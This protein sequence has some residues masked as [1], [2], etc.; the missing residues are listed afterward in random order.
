[1]SQRYMKI[2]DAI[3]KYKVYLMQIYL[4]YAE[5]I[6]QINNIFIDRQK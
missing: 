3:H 1:M 6:W 2:I 5:K 4:A